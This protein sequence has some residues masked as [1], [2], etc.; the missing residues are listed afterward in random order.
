LTDSVWRAVDSNATIHRAQYSAD[1][2]APYCTLIKLSDDSFLVY[3]S[4]RGQVESAKQ[5]LPE[6]PQLILLAPAAGHTL[7]LEEWQNAFLKTTVIA[8]IEANARIREKTS[9][10]TVQDPDSIHRSLPD[11]VQ[12]HVVPANKLGEIWVSIETDEAG[13][14]IY[15][16]VC[17]SF[18]NLSELGVGLFTRIFFKLYGLGIG[19]RIHK[20]FRNGVK[21]KAEFLQ[22]SSQRLPN[23]KRNVL[24]PCHGV[25]YDAPDLSDRMA[26][27]ISSNFF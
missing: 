15:W 23:D 21:D 17:D 13:G 24:L 22:W 18:M 10:I 25:V 6:N 3:S 5:L 20:A 14:T 11:H 2:G 16:A 1:M 19:I 12:L 27:L 9:I 8:S 4:G 7:G 26:E